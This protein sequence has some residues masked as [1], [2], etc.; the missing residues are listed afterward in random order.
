MATETYNFRTHSY[1]ITPEATPSGLGGDGASFS[2][3]WNSA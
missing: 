3:T 1:V 2:V